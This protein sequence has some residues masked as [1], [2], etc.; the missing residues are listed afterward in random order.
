MRCERGPVTEQA[1]ALF[2]RGA[3]AVLTLLRLPGNER[4]RDFSNCGGPCFNLGGRDGWFTESVLNEAVRRKATAP[5]RDVI[6]APGLERVARFLWHFVREVA[7][8]P[9]AGRGLQP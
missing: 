1:Q 9:R 5:G 8:A 2:R 4:G 6:S 3:V 7:A